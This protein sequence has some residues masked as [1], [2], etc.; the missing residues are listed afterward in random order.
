[1]LKGLM[2]TLAEDLFSDENRDELIKEINEDVDIPL[3]NEK[4]EEKILLALTIIESEL[5]DATNQM[6]EYNANSDARV[7]IDCAKNELYNL[8]DEIEKE[9]L[10]EKKW[11]V[12]PRNNVW[13]V[14]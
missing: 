4:T 9:I 1:M 13:W 3:L 11:V 8:K 10:D 2:G 5:D 6:P 14:G 7:S 12:E